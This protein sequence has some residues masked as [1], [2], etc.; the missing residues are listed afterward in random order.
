MDRG[1][2]SCTGVGQRRGRCAAERAISQFLAG[3]TSRLAGAPHLVRDG[4]NRCPPSTRVSYL[5]SRGL[6]ANLGAGNKLHCRSA[7]KHSPAHSKGR[8]RTPRREDLTAEV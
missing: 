8:K 7:G 2:D 1:L 3:S 5:R 4:V 6:S